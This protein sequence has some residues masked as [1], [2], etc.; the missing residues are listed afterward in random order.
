[1]ESRHTRSVKR[2]AVAKADQ[3]KGALKKAKRVIESIEGEERDLE[4]PEELATNSITMA[5]MNELIRDL[6]RTLAES[7][8]AQIEA[9]RE[10]QRAREE[11]T[12]E[13]FR[14]I[15]Q[16]QNDHH[17]RDTEV[18]ASEFEKLR[19][20][21]EQARGRQTQ[22]LPNFDG[23]NIEVDEWQDKVEA[24]MNC[25]NWD[26]AKLLEALPTYLSAQ[27]KR[28]FDSL[29][30]DDKRTKESLFQN[31]RVKID[32]QSEKKNKEK[33]MMARKGPSESIMSYVDRCRMYIRR[34]G[35]NPTEAFAKDMLRYKVYDSLTPTD[36]K[37]LN[38]T[39]GAEEELES[40]ILKAD[41][42]LGTQPGVIGAVLGQEETSIPE[43]RPAWGEANN[44]QAK[45][46]PR[47]NN[48]RPQ[49]RNSDI[50]C[51]QCGGVGHIRRNCIADIPEDQYMRN[52]G[53]GFYQ[54]QAPYRM[55]Q[56][57]P[58]Q[59]QNNQQGWR[60]QN[61]AGSAPPRMGTG[62]GGFPRQQQRPEYTLSQNQP[63]HDGQRP[64][65]NPQIPRPVGQSNNNG[66]A[67]PEQS[68]AQNSS[69]LN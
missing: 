35:G 41:S 40:I 56:Q 48:I 36:R 3:V 4:L 69:P 18:L 66:V 59:F 2:K 60:N 26:I 8:N 42:M 53:Q 21:K 55:R 62:R 67:R 51:Y 28:A 20:E 16:G 38:A 68:Q 49:Q 54:R 63:P 27:A 12:E 30:D 61:M 15:I 14:E 64:V 17:R 44:G 9:Q 33:F 47:G 29:T 45:Y 52:Q 43:G 25:N 39:V 19:L 46:Q 34:S 57:N 58:N 5:E 1:M 11:A 31:M 37:I 13:R 65:G 10:F 32:P 50:I 6:S 7:L 24:V 23:L 22:K